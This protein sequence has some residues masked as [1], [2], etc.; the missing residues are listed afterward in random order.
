MKEKAVKISEIKKAGLE[1][2]SEDSFKLVTD[3]EELWV[4]FKDNLNSEDKSRA[5]M[6]CCLIKSL[7]GYETKISFQPSCSGLW[8]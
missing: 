1:F 4:Y 3:G 6:F 8:D 5:I 2:F 7:C